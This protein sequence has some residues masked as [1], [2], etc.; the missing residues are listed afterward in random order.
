MRM[1]FCTFLSYANKNDTQ[2]M[3]GFLSLTL[4]HEMRRCLGTLVLNTYT[5]WADYDNT[6][7]ILV[8]KLLI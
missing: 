8:G 1:R 5:A 3:C 4:A 6:E 2:E 7:I